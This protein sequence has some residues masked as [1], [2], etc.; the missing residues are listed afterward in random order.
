MIMVLGLVVFVY[1]VLAC[2]I[3]QALVGL[4]LDWLDRIG[5]P[6][7]QYA[8][9]ALRHIAADSQLTAALVVGLVLVVPLTLK[10]NASLERRVK[11][12]VDDSDRQ[13]DYQI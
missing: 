7:E 12:L 8:P 10:V 13:N 3:M 2:W 5:I 11:Q 4:P 9:E 1:V 6:V